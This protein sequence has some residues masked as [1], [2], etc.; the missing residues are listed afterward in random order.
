[1]SKSWEKLTIFKPKAGAPVAR[2]T[3]ASGS[4]LD[5]SSRQQIQ[6][7]PPKQQKRFLKKLLKE[8]NKSLRVNKNFWNEA[9]LCDTFWE[10]EC[11]IERAGSVSRW[12]G[13]GSLYG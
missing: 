10:P 7:W 11:H 13:R 4:P 5:S 3:S 6:K 8:P 1:M 12:I 2:R 9:I